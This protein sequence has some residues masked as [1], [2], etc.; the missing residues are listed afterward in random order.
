M[1]KSPA[2][3]FYPD[4]WLTDTRRLTYKAKG[5]FWDTCCFVWLQFQETCSV[6]NDDKF[7]SGEIGCALE[8]WVEAK[9]ELLNE[10]RPIIFLDQE[11]NRLLF[12]GLLKEAEKQ[13]ER[14][15]TLSANGSLGGRPKKQKLSEDKL[16][17]QKVIFEK[18]KENQTES[19][20]SPSPSPALALETPLSSLEEAQDDD[21]SECLEILEFLNAKT[22]R[23]FRPIDSNL[24]IIKARLS[25]SGVTSCGVEKMIERQC[26]KWKGTDMEEYLR[27]ETLFRKSKFDSYYASRELPINGESSKMQPNYEE[28]F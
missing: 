12:R 28:G 16:L 22:G 20:P 13:R 4:K 26:K 19:L 18:P 24:S 8:D 7:I 25:E 14:R 5:I 6:P 17:K 11:T 21:K 23:E 2:F 3:Q 9:K 27:P 10:H 1:N 15:A